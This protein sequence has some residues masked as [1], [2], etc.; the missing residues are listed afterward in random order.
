MKTNYELADI[1]RLY[2]NDFLAKNKIPKYKQKIL[3]DIEKCRTEYFGGHKFQ[4]KTCGHTVLRY[5][6]CSNRHC[7]KC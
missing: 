2:K 3:K 5:N 1:L 7:P 6:S 4:C